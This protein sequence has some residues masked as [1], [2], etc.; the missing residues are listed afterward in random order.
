[1]RTSGITIARMR[2]A[3]MLL[4]NYPEA[5]LVSDLPQVLVHSFDEL[6]RI[7]YEENELLY[8]VKFNHW[9]G[10]RRA[11]RKHWV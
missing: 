6:T 4:S 1:M 5:R 3:R 7:V 10:N 9:W 8:I 11:L 2:L